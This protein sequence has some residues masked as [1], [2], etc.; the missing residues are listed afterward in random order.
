MDRC[1][2]CSGWLSVLEGWGKVLGDVLL[3]EVVMVGVV[4]MMVFMIGLLVCMK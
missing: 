4:E 2:L 3:D 1:R